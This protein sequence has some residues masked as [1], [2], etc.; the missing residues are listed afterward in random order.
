MARRSYVYS[1]RRQQYFKEFGKDRDKAKFGESVLAFVIRITP[2]WGP[3]RILK[4]RIPNEEAEKIFL[5]S[6]DETVLSYRHEVAAIG[7]NDIELS[8]IDWD[9]GK[10]TMQGEY[11][12]AD[13]TY[14]DW[15]IKLKE[16]NFET[17]SSSMKRN[18]LAF[19]KN[20][21]DSGIDDEQWKQTAAALEE[22]KKGK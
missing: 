4:F 13:K 14:S 16:K 15:V 18:I 17:T 6:F 21:P 7:R 9:T 2:K 5:E 3:L 1:M 8:N 11:S 10:K 22:L 20:Y 19:Y 12:L